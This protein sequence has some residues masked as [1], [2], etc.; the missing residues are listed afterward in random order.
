MSATEFCKENLE[1]SLVVCHY[2]DEKKTDIVQFILK[3]GYEYGVC[4][5]FNFFKPA[6]DDYQIRERKDRIKRSSKNISSA[7]VQT[8]FI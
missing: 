2:F 7:L 4:M 6:V 1:I 8:K 5:Q 3:K